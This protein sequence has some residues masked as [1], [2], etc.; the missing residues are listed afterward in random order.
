MTYFPYSFSLITMV[1][2]SLSPDMRMNVPISG[3]VKTSSMASIASRMSVAFFLLV[4][5][6]GAKIRSIDDSESG[7]MYCG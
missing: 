1:E 6:A 5:N 3:R 2:K 7:T 4:P